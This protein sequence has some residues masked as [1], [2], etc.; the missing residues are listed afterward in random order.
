MKVLTSKNAIILIILCTCIYAV[1]NLG[2]N[3]FATNM[4]LIGSEFSV[5]KEEL[6]IVTSCLFFAYGIGQLVHSFLSKYY[7]EKIVVPLVLL[8]SAICN[9]LI[10][11]LPNFSCFKYIWVVDG[12]A[13]SFIWCNILN[14]EAKFLS[15]KDIG[16]A[17]IWV[18]SS[19]CMGFAVLSI[20]SSVFSERNW[21]ITFYIIFVVMVVA[22]ILFYTIVSY[23]QKTEKVEELTEEELSVVS[24][25]K[26]TNKHSKR[27]IAMI[28]SICVAAVI[29]SFV[30]SGLT[31]WMPVILKESFLMKDVK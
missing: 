23:M 26:T 22:A 31:T 20:L 13:Q 29:F 9:L 2:R 5:S 25:E 27:F 15:K 30:R 12:I 4:T 7:N 8:V 18:G 24:T 17:I 19:Q 10:G 6:G 16:Y 21:R 1:A 3:S 11:I 14:L 28:V